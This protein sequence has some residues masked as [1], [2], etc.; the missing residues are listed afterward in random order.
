LHLGSPLIV[1]FS[2][3]VGHTEVRAKL[4]EH[5]KGIGWLPF[6]PL[7]LE[8]VELILF[9]C[10]GI[11]DVLLSGDQ[12]RPLLHGKQQFLQKG[13]DP[14]CLTRLLI[15]SRLVC[16]TLL[17]GITGLIGLALGFV[18]VELR[19]PGLD[20]CLGLCIVLR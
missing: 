17:L 19:E 8:L 3:M 12:D 14:G 2:G 20:Q 16:G 15:F 1:D 6:E 10:Q 18:L 13:H 11:P 5:G 7:A 9:V 4:I